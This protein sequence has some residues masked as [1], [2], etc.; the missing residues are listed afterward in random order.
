MPLNMI[1][2]IRDAETSAERALADA[3]RDAAQSTDAAERG[4]RQTIDAVRKTVR[5]EERRLIEEAEGHA[6]G[7]IEALGS[8]HH[9]ELARLRDH[10]A[11][12]MPR[13]ADAI[14]AALLQPEE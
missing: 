13:A 4:A 10:A 8:E 6:R 2:A 7:R 5:A 12:N 3:K 9:T 14:V 1:N 11:A